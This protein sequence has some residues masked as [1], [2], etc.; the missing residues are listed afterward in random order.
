MNITGQSQDIA[1][2]TLIF[3]SGA[4]ALLELRGASQNDEQAQAQART[5]LPGC[6]YDI[7]P[8]DQSNGHAFCFYSMPVERGGVYGH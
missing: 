6:E 4:V 1:T 7:Q 5:L 3:A 2:F 8:G